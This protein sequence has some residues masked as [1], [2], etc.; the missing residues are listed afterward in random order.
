MTL[1]SFVFWPGADGIAQRFDALTKAY[2]TVAKDFPEE[3][4]KLSRSQIGDARR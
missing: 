2:E 1:S 3:P 4:T